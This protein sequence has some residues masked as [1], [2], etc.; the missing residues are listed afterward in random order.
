M[1]IIIIMIHIF[2]TTCYYGFLRKIAE[3]TD[4]YVNDT[5][6][7]ITIIMLGILPIVN[8]ILLI[9][10]I[11]DYFMHVCKCDANDMLRKILII[12]DNKKK[13]G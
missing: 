11:S 1:L 2:I 4:Y 10:M 8:L 5:S 9:A 3:R 12:K 13:R 6:E 7:L